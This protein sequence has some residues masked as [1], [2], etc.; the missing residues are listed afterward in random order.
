LIFHGL[1]FEVAVE[2][3]DFLPLLFGF[4]FQPVC[5]LFFACI[6]AC[7]SGGGAE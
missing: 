5:F 4:L 6:F 3:F 1:E 7:F 2:G